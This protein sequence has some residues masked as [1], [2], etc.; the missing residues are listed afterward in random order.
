MERQTYTV[1]DASL[2]FDL[3]LIGDIEPTSDLDFCMTYTLYSCF[4]YDLF[5][6]SSSRICP[7]SACVC[8]CLCVVS[9]L[10]GV[11]TE[12]LPFVNVDVPVIHPASA[13]PG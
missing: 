3:A 8:V 10:N 13:S 5:T 4:I 12:V 2:T 7:G 1:S 9:G 11:V 6:C